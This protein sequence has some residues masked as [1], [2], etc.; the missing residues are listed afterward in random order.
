M[1]RL[2]FSG[3]W[4]VLHARPH[5]YNYFLDGLPSHYTDI[6]LNIDSKVILFSLWQT[7]KC[8]MKGYLKYLPIIGF[9]WWCTEFVFLRRNWQ[10]DRR[11]LESS[12]STLADFPFPFWVSSSLL[13]L[14]LLLL[15]S[16]SSSFSNIIFDV[17]LLFVC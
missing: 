5:V 9:S 17:H 16:S 15:S 3:F 2:A 14:L 13:L 4:E 12:L 6:H 7:C 11:V 8:Y 1:V 10:K